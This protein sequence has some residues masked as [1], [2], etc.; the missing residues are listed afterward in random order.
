MAPTRKPTLL[1]A[2][3]LGSTL[4]AV[5]C[6]AAPR[7]QP[8]VR[9]PIAPARALP[10]P[11]AATQAK[12]PT[13]SPPP[14]TSNRDALRVVAFAYDSKLQST[15]ISPTLGLVVGRSLGCEGKEVDTLKHACG[16]RGLVALRP[17]LPGLRTMIELGLRYPDEGGVECVNEAQVRCS[18]SP[19]GEC[20][21]LYELYFIDDALVAIVERDDWQGPDEQRQ[22]LDL[23][24]QTLLSAA[25]C[26]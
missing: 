10:P 19:H 15:I 16:A 21:P 6:G 5:G 11:P 13:A 9:E 17:L 2:L 8:V 3:A 12:S 4:G 26:P 1:F 23:R 20:Q 14:A 7:S 24:V 22:A 18:V 25:E